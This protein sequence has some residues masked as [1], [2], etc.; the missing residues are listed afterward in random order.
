MLISRTTLH[1]FKSILR[2]L[3]DG[4]QPVSFFDFAHNINFI[5]FSVN[6]FWNWSVTFQLWDLQKMDK[7]LFFKNININATIYDNPFGRTCLNEFSKIW[8]GT[9]NSRS[10]L[11]FT[12]IITLRFTRKYMY[13]YDCFKFVVFFGFGATYCCI[14]KYM[15]EGLSL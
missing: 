6:T 4:C 8:F 13:G 14:I 5:W 9:L 15:L 3:N 1:L 7:I 12:I 10:Q 2:L 11:L